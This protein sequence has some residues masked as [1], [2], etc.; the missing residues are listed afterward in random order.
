MNLD[1]YQLLAQLGAGTDGVAYRARDR[2]G[3]RLV[4]V[5]LLGRARV[6]ED[7]WKPLVERLRL[8]ALLHHPGAVQIHDLNPQ[9]DAPYVTIDWL[10]KDLTDELADRKP[11]AA[12]RAVT[13]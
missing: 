3:D 4:E 7:R 9:G 6:D 5:R 12:R 13:L 10:E 1:R 11:L 8:A 2:D